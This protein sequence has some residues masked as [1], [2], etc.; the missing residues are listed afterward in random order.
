MFFITT[1]CA[2][3]LFRLS[4]IVNISYTIAILEQHLF[5]LEYHVSLLT[6]VE[7]FCDAFSENRIEAFLK[8]DNGL[9][10][11]LIKLVPAKNHYQYFCLLCWLLH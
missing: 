4:N 5:V 10:P 8:M 1:M 2:L 7:I 3:T 11:T 6:E 9:P